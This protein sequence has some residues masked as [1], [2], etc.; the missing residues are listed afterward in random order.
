MC[1]HGPQRDAGLTE[2]TSD[3]E[4]VETGTSDRL[5]TGLSHNQGPVAGPSGTAHLAENDLN[6]VAQ[7]SV[8]PAVADTSHILQIVCPRSVA[9]LLIITDS[10]RCNP[11]K[12]RLDICSQKCNGSL[13]I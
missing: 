6:A 13:P 5:Q 1:Y 11:C 4:P 8:A 10:H 2:L 12:I 9:G 3:T 7:P